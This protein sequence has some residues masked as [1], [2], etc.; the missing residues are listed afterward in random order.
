LEQKVNDN[1]YFDT[2]STSEQLLK[3]QKTIFKLDAGFMLK[4]EKQDAG[5][6]SSHIY[7]AASILL[8]HYACIMHACFIYNVKIIGSTINKSATRGA[9]PTCPCLP[10]LLVIDGS[11]CCC[12]SAYARRC[13]PLRGG[14]LLRHRPRQAC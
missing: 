9:I 6:S 8:G 10:S 14:G 4:E 12:S 7:N 13:A 1:K 5:C 3:K 11:S 2:G